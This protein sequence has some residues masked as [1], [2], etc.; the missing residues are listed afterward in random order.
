MAKFVT[1]GKSK[2]FY[3]FLKNEIL[4]GEYKADDKFPSI[5]DLSA[6]HG[7]SSIT[8]NSVISNLVNE[9]L[10][11]VEQGRGTFVADRRQGSSKGR[12]MI[13]VMF[14]DF[15]MENNVE[16]G[17]FNAI[18]EGLAE[19]YYVIPYNFYNKLD[20][21][22]KGLKGL[23]E[24]GVD[25]MILVPPASE[26]YDPDMVKQIVGEDIPMVFINRK[27]PSIKADF[28]T[29]DFEAADYKATKH[30]LQ[31]GRKSIALIKSDSPSHS[32]LMC[33]GYERA[34]REAGLD[35]SDKWLIEWH[36]GMN[37]AEEA[38]RGILS[39]IDGLVGSDVIIYRLRKVLYESGK[40]IPEDIAIVGIN[41][42]V[43]SRFMRPS[44]TSVPFPSH[45]IGTAAIKAIISRLE[46]G[47][48]EDISRIFE[49]EIIS[50]GSA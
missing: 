8:V 31:M 25:G 20:L 41:D 18:N 19:G 35:F 10:L 22:Y 45:E 32:R 26:D 4:S 14:F 34:Y 38:L 43:Y 17:M 24:L 11:Y 47:R 28:F 46:M 30:L 13:G 37:V 6:Q 29:M 33:N 2:Q 42:T 3:D 9:G 7:I 23:T 40:S 48:S 49:T 1:I 16:A 50:R 27:I 36:R 5:R 44:L 21:F 15:S 12:R 39:S